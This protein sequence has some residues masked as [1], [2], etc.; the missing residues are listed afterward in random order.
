MVVLCVLRVQKLAASE[1]RNEELSEAVGA[2]AA[3]L[4]RQMDALRQSHQSQQ[5]N[6][7][8]LE[9]QLLQR[10]SEYARH[11]RSMLTDAS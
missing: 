3:P 2:A 5:H 7:E 4:M 1:A 10:L 6:W 11:H 8:R 9:Q